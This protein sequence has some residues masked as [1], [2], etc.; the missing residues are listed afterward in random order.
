MLVSDIYI[1]VDRVK[2]NAVTI[3]VPFR[4]ELLRV[5]FHGIL[6]LIGYKDKKPAEQKEMRKVEEEW[7]DLF[8]KE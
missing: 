7:L 1:S 2:E 8:G 5:L 3:G 4:Q 6:H